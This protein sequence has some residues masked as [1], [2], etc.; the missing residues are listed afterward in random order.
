[1]EI[2]HEFSIEDFEGLQKFRLAY[3][4]VYPGH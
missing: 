3:I 1:M 2:L 4:S